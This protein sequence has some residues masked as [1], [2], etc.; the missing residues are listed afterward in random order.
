MSKI[1]G[2]SGYAR[3][4]KD[5]FCTMMLRSLQNRGFTA[6]R[7]ALADYL[8]ISMRDGILNMFGI[9]LLDCTSE[10]K[11]LL[12]PMMVAYGGIRRA[13]SEG[14]FF[15][16]YLTGRINQS[17]SDYVIITDIRYDEYDRDE[18]SWLKSFKNS[19][20]I[21]IERYDIKELGRKDYVGPA[22]ADEKNN[23]WK[24]K[25]KADFLFEWPSCSDDT[26]TFSMVEDFI[27]KTNIFND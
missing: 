19:K 27:N 20:L 11:T 2:L 5:T 23:F 13:Q 3:S 10:E 22:N 16:N 14:T 9:D 8:K 21:A 7:M 4:G 15:T 1:I 26:R 6:E 18:I 12:R 24:I 25:T 17:V